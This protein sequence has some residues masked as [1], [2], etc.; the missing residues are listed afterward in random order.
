MAR[1]N[2]NAEMTI[3]E[4]VNEYGVQNAE[5]K[6][7]KSVCD[8][9]NKSI[10]DYLKNAN[11]SVYESTEYTVKQVIS[12]RESFDEDALINVLKQNGILAPIKTKEYVDMAELENY[13]YNTEMTTELATA[14][15]G[16]R[17][18]TEVVSLRVSETKHKED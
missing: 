4:L 1:I 10:K 6:R 15:D 17:N 5:L 7:V 2:L 14:L 3:D 13:L 12:K 18:V 9:Y 16:C 11:L 8:N